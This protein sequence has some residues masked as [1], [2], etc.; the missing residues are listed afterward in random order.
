MLAAA[1][2]HARV[3]FEH[4]VRE[5][6][7]ENMASNVFRVIDELTFNERT[8][9]QR[10]IESC[11][12]KFIECVELYDTDRT[13]ENLNAVHLA[14]VLPAPAND[15]EAFRDQTETIIA[16]TMTSV[17][18]VQTTPSTWE[19]NINTLKQ[20]RGS[21]LTDWKHHII[22]IIMYS[23]KGDVFPIVF[24]YAYVGFIP[25]NDL[26]AFMVDLGLIYDI[27]G[28]M[29]LD[30][31]LSTLEGP[32]VDLRRILNNMREESMA[33]FT[34]SL[35]EQLTRAPIAHF[36]KFTIGNPTLYNTVFEKLTEIGIAYRHTSQGVI[37]YW[38]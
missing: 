35:M 2:H 26:A 15:C 17:N 25:S 1:I 34:R 6:Y 29:Y 8:V 12:C 21:S 38:L 32:L 4:I 23:G 37:C 19:N 27:K 36:P 11:F 30:M 9:Y 24:R 7:H 33:A 16:N 18:M 22:R 13:I 28:Y 14:K 31:R 3:T 5:F 20:H 10:E